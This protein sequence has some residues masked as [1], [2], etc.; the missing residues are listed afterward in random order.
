MFYLS[1]FNNFAYV[2]H[3]YYYYYYVILLLNEIS[4]DSDTEIK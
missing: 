2:F 4:V 1:Y 3:Y